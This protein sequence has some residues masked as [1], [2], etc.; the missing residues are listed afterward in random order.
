MFSF[1]THSGEFCNHAH[2]TLEQVIQQAAKQRMIVVGLSE[3]MPRSRPQDL[4][5]EESHLAPED[6]HRLFHQYVQKARSLQSKY[7]DQINVL[8][9][10]ET[11]YITKESLV[12]AQ[13]LQA[14]YQLDYLVGSVHHI[15]EWPLDFSQ[16]KYNQL[17]EEKF[18]GDRESMFCRYFDQQLEML[19]TLKPQVV[20]HFD[21]I[22]IFHP[23]NEPDP[24]VVSDKARQKALRN[25]EYAIGYGALFEINTRAWK[26][27]LRDAYPQR[28][29][30]REILQ[31]QGKLTL[32]DDSHGWQDVGM[33]YDR[34]HSYL[35]EMGV[36]RLHYLARTDGKVMT[37]VLDT[38]H[39]SF[40]SLV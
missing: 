37:K 30:L 38:R 14:K 36:A 24:L 27:H 23:T 32:S 17:L 35:E 6:L 13:Q 33:Y 28:D 20:G 4:Y 3:H 9:G 29:L 19:E 26:K 21:L 1:H 10:M 5:P 25:I 8:V 7:Q 18:N 39:L 22:R 12:E 31:R 16:E 11:E 40:F 34:L 15:D 2:G